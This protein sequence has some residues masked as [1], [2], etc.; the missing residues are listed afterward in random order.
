[1]A[2]G[3]SLLHGDADVAARAGARLR[4]LT[5]FAAAVGAPLVTIGSFRGRLAWAGEGGEE[6][7]I[8]ALR[9]GAAYA[10]ARGVRLALEPLNRYVNDVIH[11][12]KEALAFIEAVGHE[13]LGVLID[14]FHLNIEENSWTEPFREA[15]AAGLLWHVH[16][17][18]NNRLAPGWGLIDFAAIVAALREIGYSGYLSAELLAQPDGDAAAQQTL[19]HMRALV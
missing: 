4:A 16:V 18:D 15:A 5:D 10:A 8:R 19:S 17:S 1:M 7:L 12:V 2:T 13:A 9:E 3:L 11:T 6:Q 14:T